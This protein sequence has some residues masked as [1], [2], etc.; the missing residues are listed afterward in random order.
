M[1]QI[2]DGKKLAQGIAN[3]LKNEV[4]DLNLRGVKPK[5]VIVGIKPDSRSQVYIR[6]KLKRAE[7][8]GIITDYI[9]LEGVSRTECIRKVTEL[10]ND[11]NVHGI[12]LQLPLAEWYDPQELIDYIEPT[13]DADGLTS[14]NQ[15]ALEQNQPGIV[16]ATP[17][18]VMYILQN[19]YIDLENKTVTIIGR[20][21]L[22]GTPLKYLLEHAGAKVLVAHRQ[23]KDIAG[24]TR[25][26]DIVISAA[27]TPG[28]ITDGMIKKDAIVIDVGINDVDGK[29]KGDVDFDSVKDIA[30]IITP[31][32]GGVGPLTVV[33]LLQNVISSA[34]KMK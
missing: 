21:N 1:A 12:I 14:T 7:E 25:Q 3:R 5:L 24:L 9:E 30:S 13:K 28:L 15:T 10:S 4:S 8:V 16:P 19:E 32:P 33:M 22:V 29:L 23:T 34:K 2:V 11:N 18:A 6:M 31:V 17:L 26:S 20:S 27:G